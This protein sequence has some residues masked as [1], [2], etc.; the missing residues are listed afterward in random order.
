MPRLQDSW[1]LPILAKAGGQ[2][3]ILFLLFF[4]LAGCGDIPQPF[5]HEGANLVVAPVAA[6]GVV[7][8]P[9]DQ[10]PRGMQLAEAIVR[11][12]LIAEIPASTR[13]ATTGAWVISGE[14]E[15][16]AAAA[17]LRWTL[18][19]S[20]NQAQGGLEQTIPAG[21]WARATPKTMD[22]IAAEVVAK[23][24]GTLHDDAPPAAPEVQGP[25]IRL[26][27]LVGLPGDGAAALTSAMRTM[28]GRGGLKVV[29]GAAD[30]QLRGQVTVTPGRS[31]EEVL[32]VAWTV[33]S[34]TGEDIGAS[35]QEGAVPKGRL[36]GPWGSLATDIA[37]GGAEGVGEIVRNAVTPA[38]ERK[39]L[40]I[41]PSR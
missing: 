27:P 13:E 4:I 22:L 38:P 1:A 15:D 37:A 2:G 34:P 10:S 33:I 21:A 25:S 3:R 16:S 5:R 41:P 32:A 31:G 9:L 19:R 14:V 30:F 8:R 23:L 40:V 36:A 24:M 7:V 26:L 29:D 12:L 6:R 35:A 17:S 20:G 11:H 18:T 39:G 28:L